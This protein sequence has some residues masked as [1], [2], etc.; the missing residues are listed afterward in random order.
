MLAFIVALALRVNDFAYLTDV[1]DIPP[2]AWDQ[3]QGLDTLV[4]DAVRFRP[5]P[6]HFH[7]EKSVEVAQA[8][9]ANQ[10]FFTHL[11]DDYD[12]D[13]VNAQLPAGMALAYDGLEISL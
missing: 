12:H 5:H 13:V 2:A 8:L 11:S 10:T 7:F 6:N 4:L 3:L 1:S 9:G